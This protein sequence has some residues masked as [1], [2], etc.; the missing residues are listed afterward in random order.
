MVR[1]GATFE[2]DNSRVTFLRTSTETSG[3]LHEQRM[4]FFPGSRFP[5]EH[6]HPDQDE[7][8]V[9]ESGSMLFEV[10]GVKK[11]VSAGEEIRIPRGTR[12]RARNGSTTDSAIVR[13]ET[14]PALRT[15]EFFARAHGLGPHPGLLGS[16]LLAHEYRDVFRASGLGK[17]LVP[18][19]GTLA[20]LM[21]RRLPTVEEADSA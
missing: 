19:V 3:E 9:I 8:F 6:F 17:L 10:G 11:E 16:A 18:V 14:R 20:R 13:W 4:E 15:G 5:P 1:A 7:L 12:H 21:G 2:D